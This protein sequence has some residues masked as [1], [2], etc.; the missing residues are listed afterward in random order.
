VCSDLPA[1]AFDHAM[2]LEQARARLADKVRRSTVALQF[3]PAEFT[4][5]ELQAVHETILG[6]GI[7]KR[8]FRKWMAGLDYLKSTGKVRRG[9][10]HRPAALF[11]GKGGIAAVV[12]GREVEISRGTEAAS[13]Q[14]AAYQKG[15]R[16]GV[17]AVT[18]AVEAARKSLLHSSR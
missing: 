11:R 6:E 3:L 13:A 4:L 10:Q 12:P 7:D 17:R 15:Y 18:D 8:N 14:E 16:D 2:I 1:L 5:S 9:G